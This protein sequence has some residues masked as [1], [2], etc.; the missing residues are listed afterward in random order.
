MCKQISHD[1]KNIHK[2]P[3][4]KRKI[5]AKLKLSTKTTKPNNKTMGFI[6]IEDNNQNVIWPF[7]K[8]KII[9]GKLQHIWVFRDPPKLWPTNNIRN[10]GL[11][12]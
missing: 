4:F 8:Q 7:I 5:C 11:F 2:S 12:D 6:E 1:K 9:K 3:N 10:H